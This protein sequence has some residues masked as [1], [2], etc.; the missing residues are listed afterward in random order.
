MKKLT[1]VLTVI[2]ILGIFLSG[3][4]GGTTSS[5]IQIG[6]EMNNLKYCTQIK[7]DRDYIEKTD[8]TFSPGQTF[9]VYF[10]VEGLKTKNENGLYIYHPVVTAQ[11]KDSSGDVII[12]ETRVVDRELKT[13][14]TAEYLYFPIS[15][16]LPKNAPDGKYTLTLKVKDANGN[17]HIT[18]NTQFFIKSSG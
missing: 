3:C 9:Y 15:I 7:G 18:S 11:I 6:L 4:N 17:G 16:T 14:K 10:E 5:T 2:F 12:P 8:K 1:T 13:D